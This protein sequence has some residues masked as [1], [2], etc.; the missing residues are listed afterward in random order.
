MAIRIQVKDIL[1]PD[2][3]CR[4]TKSF[5]QRQEGDN[6][7]LEEKAAKLDWFSSS[8]LWNKDA[9]GSD[10]RKIHYKSGKWDQEGLSK[11]L[12]SRMKWRL[13][14]AQS[15]RSSGV[16]VTPQ[17]CL[18]QRMGCKPADTSF[19]MCTSQVVSSSSW[20]AHWKRDAGAGCW[21]WIHMGRWFA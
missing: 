4:P 2:G 8:S 21:K 16:K 13:V 18:A 11:D 17:S 5:F 20:A 6:F 9:L 10:S 12:V 14:L 19:C 1:H 15:F 3:V 7:G